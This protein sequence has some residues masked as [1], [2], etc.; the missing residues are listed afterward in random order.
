MLVF[1]V[2]TGSEGVHYVALLGDDGMIYDTNQSKKNWCK[3]SQEK[4][5][6]KHPDWPLK[7][8]AS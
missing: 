1:D 3:G 8:Y 6:R 4:F 5:E 7:R 2:T